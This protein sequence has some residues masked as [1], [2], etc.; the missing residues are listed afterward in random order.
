MRSNMDMAKSV[1]VEDA[2]Q[3]L[4]VS[5]RTVYYRIREGRL[6]TVRTANGTRRVLM[7]SI[8]TLLREASGVTIRGVDAS[9]TDP[10]EKS[11]AI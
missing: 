7:E 3:L 11:P 4:G 8:E 5:R 2:A 6:Q 10:S 1:F 9:D